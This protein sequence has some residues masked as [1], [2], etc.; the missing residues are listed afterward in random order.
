MRPEKDFSPI[1][2]SLREDVTPIAEEMIYAAFLACAIPT[3]VAYLLQTIWTSSDPLLTVGNAFGSFGLVTCI[4][5]ER[6][7]RLIGHPLLNQRDQAWIMRSHVARVLAGAGTV[8]GGLSTLWIAIAPALAIHVGFARYGAQYCTSGAIAVSLIFA[9]WLPSKAQYCV[10]THAFWYGYPRDAAG[11]AESS[12]WHRLGL[13]LVA[14][15]TF[16][17]PAVACFYMAIKLHG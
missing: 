6:R 7:L 16:L 17:A 15:A 5:A 1:S 12:V 14:F 8:F 10:Q 9:L 13:F 4:F 2:N 11:R 3:L